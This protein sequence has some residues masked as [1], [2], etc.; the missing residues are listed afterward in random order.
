MENGKSKTK[1]ATKTKS[2]TNTQEKTKERSNVHRLS[3]QGDL[4]ADALPSNNKDISS[5]TSQTKKINLTDHIKYI[6]HISKE[7]KG[8]RGDVI[9]NAMKP[10]HD[11][12]NGLGGGFAAYGIYPEYKDFPQDI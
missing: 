3:L 6:A 9:T 12:S 11:R 10:M 4:R 2:K 1:K 5:L 8:I 7:G